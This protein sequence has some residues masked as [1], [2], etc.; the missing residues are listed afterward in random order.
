MGV[1]INNV[2]VYWPDGCIPYTVQGLDAARQEVV[3]NAI[4]AW[5][6]NTDVKF[7]VRTT[8]DNYIRFTNFGTGTPLVCSSPV[9][10]QGGE[11][12]I[13]LPNNCT[14]NS[15]A[16]EIGHAL[17]I[18]HEH[19]RSDRDN[20]ITVDEGNVW[21]FLAYNYSKLDGFNSINCG[22]YDLDSFMHYGNG[23]GS[24][25]AIDQTQPII[26]TVD[27]GDSNR[28]GSSNMSSGDRDS[29]A[30][31]LHGN[32][33]VFQMSNNGN[34]DKTIAQ[35]QWTNGWTSAA[36]YTIG[37]NNY[38][39]LL[40]SGSGRMHVNRINSDGTIGDLVDN[41]DWSN[42][43]TTVAPFSDG[44]NHYL[45]LLK[46]DSGLMH[47]NRVNANGTIGALIDNRD[48]S[49]GW[50]SAAPFRVGNMNYLFLLKTSSGQMHINQINPNGTI[51]A[52]IDH[53]DWS[54]GY[55]SAVPFRIGVNTF[56]FLYKRD[57]G[58]MRI[59]RINQDGTVGNV[60]QTRTLYSAWDRAFPLNVGFNNYLLLS[61]SASGLVQIR[62]MNAD[63]T[64]QE[65]RDSRH[66]TP[67][68]ATMAV[69]GAGMPKYVILIKP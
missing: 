41:Q 25:M 9:G 58:Y 3:L 24:V 35:Y 14:T 17:G 54:S 63:G 68:W 11:Q 49:S 36:A 34:I 1:I 30:C 12:V 48:W 20:Y 57:D 37:A 42:G 29:A 15:V 5:E 52:L 2:L 44:P 69:F 21:P 28:I 31:I 10:M 32:S 59:R 55:S 19:R 8:Q 67:G 18:H 16:H 45:F 39:I 43:W 66:L 26:T 33:K 56:L 40:K 61:N 65:S 13:N 51:G 27:P 47:V 46:V 62:R 53:R 50:T 4:T 22:D 38:L 60:I 23:L 7:V 6:N 64:V